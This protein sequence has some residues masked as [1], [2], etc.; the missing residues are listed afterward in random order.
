MS[1]IVL[2]ENTEEPLIQSLGRLHHRL[3]RIKSVL[4]YDRLSR[5]LVDKGTQILLRLKYQE[6]AEKGGTLPFSE[7][8]FS[9]FSQTD[10]DGI[11]HYIFSLIGTTDKRCIEMCAGTGA[12]CNTANLIINQGWHGLLVDGDAGNVARGR[13]FFARHSGTEIM[14]PSYR[15]YW[16]TRDTVDALFVEEGFTEEIDLL[17]LDLD[18]VDYWIWEAIS[19]ISPRV[20][21]AEVMPQLGEKAITVPY[22]DDFEAEW[23][24]LD[25][26]PQL[27]G[28][29]LDGGFFAGRTLYAGASLAAFNKLARRKGYR[30]VGAN[31]IGFNA[32]FVRED[33]AADLF[34]EVSEASCVNLSYRARFSRAWEALRD[35]EWQEV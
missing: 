23:I 25:E 30:L 29:P 14:G 7:V 28:I 18:G 9:N 11:L 24:S 21:V 26:Q 4:D 12:Q 33:V 16:I 22:S 13:D 19:A 5:Q 35:H 2:A 15:Q 8:G 3:E 6:L 27:G 34:P 20:V 31:A 10:E 1:G 17:S 32:F